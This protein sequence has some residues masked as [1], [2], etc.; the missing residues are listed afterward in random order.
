LD[1]L[2]KFL[3][4]GCP[5]LQIVVVEKAITARDNARLYMAVAS[6]MTVVHF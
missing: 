3:Q 1:L 4:V 2:A 6:E 5:V